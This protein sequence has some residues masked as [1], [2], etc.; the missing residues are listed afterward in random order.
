MFYVTSFNEYMYFCL[1]FC[2]NN[3]SPLV[4]CLLFFLVP[5]LLITLYG[6]HLVLLYKGMLDG[7]VIESPYVVGLTRDY[8]VVPNYEAFKCLC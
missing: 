6:N 2:N 8:Q 1:P 4:L 3:E 5:L 7:F